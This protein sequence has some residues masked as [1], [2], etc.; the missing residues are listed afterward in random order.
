MTGLTGASPLR[1]KCEICFEKSKLISLM[2]RCPPPHG[3]RSALRRQSRSTGDWREQDHTTTTNRHIILPGRQHERLQV[4]AGALEEE[5]ERCHALL[6]ARA[7]LGVPVRPPQGHVPAR[8]RR[9]VVP[10]CRALASPHWTPFLVASCMASL[11]A[12]RSLRWARSRLHHRVHVHG[13]PAAAC[14]VSA[15]TANCPRSCV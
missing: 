11:Y 5:A 14:L 7:R 8:C 12:P 10:R 2:F 4:P 15:P 3:H 6:A 9:C 1:S 13:S